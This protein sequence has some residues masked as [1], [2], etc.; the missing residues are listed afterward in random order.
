ML[1]QGS[2]GP[3]ATTTSVSPSVSPNLRMGNMGD[4]IFSELQPRYYESTYRRASFSGANQSVVTTAFTAGL[5]TTYTGGLVL[6][7]PFGN[8]YN[9]V[10]TK[11]GVAFVVAQTNAAVIGVAAGQS[12]T[13][14]SGTLT[15]VA[16]SSDLIG[17]GVTPTAQLYSSASITLPVAP[18]LKR[19]IGAVDTGALT[20]A[21]FGSGIVDLE[22]GIILPPGGFA[23]IYSSAT[24]TASSFFGS[25]AWCEVPI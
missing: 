3:Q 4:A 25:M 15:S 14:L 12:S 5:G 16:P 23:T 21:T 20:V 13:A 22:G 1:I 11:V 24:G 10:L 19:I 2:V 7:N 6:S 18:V 9:V 8:T 17:S